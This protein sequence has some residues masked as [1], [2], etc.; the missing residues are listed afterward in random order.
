[1]HEFSRKHPLREIAL[2]WSSLLSGRGLRAAAEQWFGELSIEDMPVCAEN[3][4]S[5]VVV[6]KATENGS[7]FKAPTS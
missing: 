7:D 5:D 4:D 6:M 1:M 2:P 3:L